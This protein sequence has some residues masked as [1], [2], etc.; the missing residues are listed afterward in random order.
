MGETKIN[1]GS[2]RAAPAER[3]P[4]CETS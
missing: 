3:C 2:D 4:S 1:E